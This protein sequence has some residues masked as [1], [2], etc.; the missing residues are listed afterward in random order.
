[1]LVLSRKCG[2]SIRLPEQDIV[3]TVLEITGNRV[4]I[5]IAAPDSVPVYREELWQRIEQRLEPARDPV[6]VCNDRARFV[7]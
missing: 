1:M 6:I 7:P 2:E 4:R 5:G 3:V